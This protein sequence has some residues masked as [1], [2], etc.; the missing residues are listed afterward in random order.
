MRRFLFR[1]IMGIFFGGFIATLTTI[2]LIYFGE[3][4]LIDG[5]LFLKNSLGSIF[6]GWLFTVTPLY[7][8]IRSLRLYQQT[9]LHFTTV[10]IL[11]LILALAIGW[12]PAE[13]KH[14]IL[15]L[16]IAV[17]TYGIAWFGFFLYFKHECR[18]LNDDLKRI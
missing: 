1:S 14:I 6:C 12:I 5:E 11:Y 13:T 16:I 2:A 10:A 15:F 9:A 7:F 3:Q 17:T 8:E 18:K 4:S